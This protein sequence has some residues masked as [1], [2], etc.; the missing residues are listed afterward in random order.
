MGRGRQKAKATK[1]ARRLKY[2]TGGT[3]L[4]RLRAELGVPDRASEDDEDPRSE[5]PYDDDEDFGGRYDGYVDDEGSS[6][7]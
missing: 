1:V 5:D 4:D 7:D 2:N 6:R 3:D